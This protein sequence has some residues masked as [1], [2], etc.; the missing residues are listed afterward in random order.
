M[1]E[2]LDKLPEILQSMF[3]SVPKVIGYFSSLG[4]GTLLLYIII[5]GRVSKIMIKVLSWLFSIGIVFLCIAYWDQIYAVIGPYIP[6]Q[7]VEFVK[8]LFGTFGTLN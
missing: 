2:I 5:I 6:P 7:V 3:D 8:S 4:G 1:Q